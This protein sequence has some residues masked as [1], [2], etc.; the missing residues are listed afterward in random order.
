MKLSNR[1]S[2]F[3]LLSQGSAFLRA[4]LPLMVVLAFPAFGCGG[5]KKKDAETALSI[6]KTI[7]SDALALLPSGPIAVARVDAKALFAAGGSGAEVTKL[8]A[9]FFPVGQ[10]AGFDAARDLTQIV[11]ASYSLQGVDALSI[12]SGTFDAAKIQK[13]ADDKTPLKGGGTLTAVPYAG[14]T[15]YA[16]QGASFCVLSPKTTLAG[17]ETAV[18]R[19][20]DRVR[21]GVP[22]RTLSDVFATTLDNAAPLTGV[23]DFT[24][25]PLGK[26]AVGP[27]VIPGTNGLQVIRL[28]GDFK[29]PGVNIAATATYDTE[30]NTQAGAEGAKKLA[31]IVAGL[32]SFAPVPKLQNFEAKPEKVDVLI[33]FAV[34]DAQLKDL[35]LALPG[36]LGAPE[37]SAAPRK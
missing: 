31:R 4:A 10:E 23:A 36:L 27:M 22:A 25:S 7:D 32:S 33:K 8:T 28:L 21:D 16:S 14:K 37:E 3:R 19:A 18:R 35:L 5:D 9:R 2:S 17:T 29:P 12:L 30:E 20:L 1:S 11:A 15:I 26:V 6:P 24:K 34:D 13:V